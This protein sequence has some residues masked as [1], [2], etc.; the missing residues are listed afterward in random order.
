MSAAVDALPAPPVDPVLADAPAQHSRSN[1][2]NQRVHL[3]LAATLGSCTRTEVEVAASGFCPEFSVAGV[4]VPA[5]R[6]WHVD[7][8][9]GLGWVPK[10][11]TGDSNFGIARQSGGTYVVV[12]PMVG[13]DITRLFY[14]RA[15]VQV[16]G[17]WSLERVAPGFHGMLNLGTRLGSH[18]ELGLRVLAGAD[19]GIT[20][21]APSVPNQ[22][23]AAYRTAWVLTPAFEEGVVAR[24]FIP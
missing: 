15:G 13:L 22:P 17:T 6:R 5:G 12:R 8:E 16:R 21:G 9:V 14:V 20:R 19:G 2:P 1:W 4:D 10:G 18:V 23:P 24:V 7:A 11:S 3:V